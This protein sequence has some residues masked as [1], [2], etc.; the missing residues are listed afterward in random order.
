LGGDQSI[1]ARRSAFAIPQVTAGLQINVD[2]CDP[3]ET[4]Q[5]FCLDTPRGAAQLES[6]ASVRRNQITPQASRPPIKSFG[7]GEFDGYFALPADGFGP[8]IV[9]LQEIF[10]VNAFLRGVADWYAAREPLVRRAHG[11]LRRRDL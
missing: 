6:T 9:V 3:R 2:C 7:G 10:G 5:Q 11:F 8:G 4:A 1:A